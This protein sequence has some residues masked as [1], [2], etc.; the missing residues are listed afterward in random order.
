MKHVLLAMLAALPTGGNASDCRLDMGPYALV[1][2][3]ERTRKIKEIVESP[4]A[5]RVMTVFFDEHPGT[6]CT[7]YPI[8]LRNEGVMPS[9]GLR[10]LVIA[11]GHSHQT[12]GTIQSL[13]LPPVKGEPSLDAGPVFIGK[14]IEDMEASGGWNVQYFW[15]ADI[16]SDKRKGATG[17]CLDLLSEGLD[18]LEIR[19]LMSSVHLKPFDGMGDC[20]E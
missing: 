7:F 13:E 1:I 19:T 18:D 11:W 16:G 12:S 8:I 2:P 5:G 17:Y 9:T 14:V 6:H 10:E 20:Q 4:K 15:M 3:E